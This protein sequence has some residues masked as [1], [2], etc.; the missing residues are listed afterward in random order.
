MADTI[1]SEVEE[2]DI[3]AGPPESANAAGVVL[4]DL[5]SMIKS[6]ITG[7]DKRKSELRKHR[8]MLASALANDETYTGQDD[9]VKK[10]VK[11]RN[12]TRSEIL[13][14][15][16]NVKINEKVKELSGEIKEMDMAL[17]DYLREYQRLSG[18]NEIETDDG[19]VR[20]I[21]YVAKLIRK[22]TRNR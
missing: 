21:V 13:K 15:Q 10:A 9:E 12:A 22:S 1:R 18:S 7:I 17:S 4:T 20:E 19:T 16:A 14:Q 11:I 8:E 6:H 2:A 3:V 5:E